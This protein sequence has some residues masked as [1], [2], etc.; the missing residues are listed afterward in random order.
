MGTADLLLLQE[1]ILRVE[2]I[3]NG[4]LTESMEAPIEV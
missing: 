4:E 2:R 3:E 1:L